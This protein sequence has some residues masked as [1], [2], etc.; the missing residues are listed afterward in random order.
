[1][2]K[3]EWLCQLLAKGLDALQIE[4]HHKVAQECSQ[5]LWQ[6]EPSRQNGDLG[7][8][9]RG[10]EVPSFAS[11][12]LWT[13]SAVTYLREYAITATKQ[14]QH[15]LYSAIL[16]LIL[17]T[18]CSY[19]KHALMLKR[20]CIKTGRIFKTAEKCVTATLW[21]FTGIRLSIKDNK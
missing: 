1:M 8:Y 14:G 12:Y 10:H 9:E 11:G 4:R 5:M 17:G 19:F 3:N 20:F 2:Q 16:F 7:W 6:E 18:H 13:A 21:Y 15:S